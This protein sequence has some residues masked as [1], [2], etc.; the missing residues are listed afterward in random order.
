M[1]VAAP[2]TSQR[3][4]HVGT[5]FEAGGVREV[6]G[7]AATADERRLTQTRDRE[8]S[9]DCGFLCGGGGRCR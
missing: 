1:S 4:N 6:A 2:A 5:G 8:S 7:T 9:G 3:P